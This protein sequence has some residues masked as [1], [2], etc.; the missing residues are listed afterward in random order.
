MRHA[1]YSPLGKQLAIDD[2]DRLW[3]ARAVEAEGAPETLVAQTLVNRWANLADTLPGLYPT[4]TELVRAYAQPV[5][6]RWFRGGDLHLE[7]IAT[8]QAERDAKGVL[9][10][11]K[12][13]DMRPAHA[14][15]TVFTSPTLEGVAQALQGPLVIPRGAVHFG[16]YRPD[17]ASEVLLRGGPGENTIYGQQ[18]LGGLYRFA[19]IPFTATPWTPALALDTAP[20]IAGLVIAAMGVAAAWNLARVY[21][22]GRR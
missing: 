11:L 10:E 18:T 17:M 4:L 7:R 2:A 19:P 14:A 12:L 15:R 13:A 8:L 21:K 20:P 6:P 16:P 22:R 9:T 3:L 5:N 1:I